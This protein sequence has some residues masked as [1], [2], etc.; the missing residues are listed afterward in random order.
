V[1]FF[2]LTPT[3]RLLNRF[4][5]DMEVLD[6]QFSRLLGQFLGCLETFAAIALG[7]VILNPVIILVIFPVCAGYCAIV[8][9]YRFASRD[10]QRLE[11]ITKT[12]IFNR[13]SETLAGLPT[14][15]S[16]GYEDYLRESSCEEIDRN[17]ACN[18]LKVQCATWLALRLEFLSLLITTSCAVIPLLPLNFQNSNA[19]FVGVALTYSLDMSRYIQAI[20]K[21]VSDMEQ[22]FTSIER[23]FEYCAVPQEAASILPADSALPKDWPPRGAIEY[24]DVTMRYRPELEPALRGLNFAVSAGEKLGVVGR[25]GSGKS[26]IIVTLLRLTEVESGT[27]LV[28]GQDVRQMGL[29]TLRQRLAMIPQEPVLFGKTTLRRNLDPFGEHADSVVMEALAKVQMDSKESV[30]DGLDTEVQEGGAPFSVGQRQ[31][32]CLARA[33]LRR[34]R[35]ILLDEATASVDNETDTLIQ[36]TVRETFQESTVLCIAHRIRTIMDSDKILVMGAGVCQE[37]GAPQE[38]LATKGSQ[39]RA[40]AEESNILVPP[41]A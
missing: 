26:S 4:T 7:I 36:R 9:Q 22:K 1:V 30:P 34:S 11:A 27:V 40:L 14:V 28:D 16:F 35:I 5:S 38:L 19:A 41:L 3:G 2:D 6:N 33:V 15:R 29:H 21:S 39:F 23:I 13:I 17:Q 37:F 12:P 24:R 10:G 20:A 25:T 31:L 32:L 18:L 8:A